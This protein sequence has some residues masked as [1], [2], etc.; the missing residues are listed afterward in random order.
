MNE[1]SLISDGEAEK[2]LDYRL[3]STY[4]PSM[5]DELDL[6]ARLLVDRSCFGLNIHRAGRA[7]AR[8]FDDAFRSAG[9]NHWQF[10]LLMTVNVPGGLSVSEL[11][12]S[13]V[14]DR[15]T[16]TANLKPLEKLNLL[17]I[18]V[19][20]DDARARRIEITEKGRGVLEQT[21]PLWQ[22]INGEIAATVLAEKDEILGALATITTA[23]T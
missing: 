14:V 4:V 5:T 8:K 6:Q 17:T 21:Y 11:A 9:I 16:I 1:T 13:L 2:A 22:R 7:V 18:R 23:N 3:I 15:T 19:D 12:R 20:E 10:A